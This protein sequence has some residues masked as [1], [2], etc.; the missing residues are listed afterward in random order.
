[1]QVPVLVVIEVPGGSSEL[2][3]ALAEAWGIET[4]PPPGNLLRMAGP[5]D[6]GWRVLSLW[7]S[8]EQFETFLEERLHLS[9]QDAGADQPVVNFLEIEKVHRFT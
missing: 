6:S 9:L 8:R 4:T 3:D 7:E 1:V 2:D 5:M